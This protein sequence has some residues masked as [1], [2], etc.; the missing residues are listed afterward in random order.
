MSKNLFVDKSCR[1]FMGLLSSKQAVPG[2]GSAAALGGALAAGLTNMVLSLTVGK[3]KYVE[4]EEELQAMLAEG[5]EL[6]NELLALADA[7]A[8]VFEP[9]SKAY[10]LPSDTNKE[11]SL[12]ER[13]L[14]KASVK[15]TKIPLAVAEKVVQAARICCRTA[16]IGT[17]MAISDIGCSA[18]FLQA[19]FEAARYNIAVNL[20]MIRDE[21][22]CTE[23]SDTT[24]WLSAELSLLAAQ[25]KKTVD[26]RLHK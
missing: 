8:E 15:A 23:V 6:Q 10:S 22:F 14:S 13:C 9:L 12:K 1:E 2:G 3:P 17:K 24:T 7:D 18:V 16:E 5:M 11:K 4:Y 25:A 26:E 21:D 20:P 19:A